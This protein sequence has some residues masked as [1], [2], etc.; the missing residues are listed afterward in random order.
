MAYKVGDHYEAPITAGEY[1]VEVVDLVSDVSK[2]K[3]TPQYTLSLR[4]LGG[5]F[6]ERII[7]HTLYITE[8]AY[9]ILSGV[10]V[11]MGV[12]KDASWDIENP[13]E[14]W[15]VLK[16]LTVKVKTYVD[17]FNGMDFAKVELFKLLSSEEKNKIKTYLVS[18]GDRS[19]DKD[20]VTKNNAAE[21]RKNRQES[22]SE[23]VETEFSGDDGEFPF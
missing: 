23:N 7:K 14:T 22:G 15:K 21:P 5:P 11:Q 13:D 19:T 10:F 9:G 12:P 8:K 17:N 16:G 1:G 6:N 3:R 18:V 4:I 2:T 20:D